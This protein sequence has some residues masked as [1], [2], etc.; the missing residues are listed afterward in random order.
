MSNPSASEEPLALRLSD[1]QLDGLMRLCQPLALH[2]RDALLRILAHELRGRCDI[3]DGELHRIARHH[4]GQS[5]VRPARS[6]RPD[7]ARQQV[8]AVIKAL[9]DHLVGASKQRR[10]H[11]PQGSAWG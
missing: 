8:G 5:P 7:T 11:W 9:F 1:T 10:R 4:Q 2:C 6:R 3:G